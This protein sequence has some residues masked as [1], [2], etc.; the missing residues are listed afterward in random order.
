MLCAALAQYNPLDDVRYVS[1]HNACI[2]TTIRFARIETVTS[3]PGNINITI[4]LS[5]KLQ[6]HD[7]KIS[8]YEQLKDVSNTA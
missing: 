1:P 4:L 7:E 8:P 6:T 2:V 3:S 5:Q